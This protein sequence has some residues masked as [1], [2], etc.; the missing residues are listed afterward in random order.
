MRSFGVALLA[1]VLLGGSLGAS[2][3]YLIRGER[4]AAVEFIGEKN[5]KA[6]KELLMSNLKKEIKNH[7]LE[8]AVEFCSKNAIGLTDMIS[9]RA[10]EGVR[11]KRVSEQYRNPANKPDHAD[12]FAY[13]YFEK[14]LKK[15][16]H[17]PQNFV[18]RMRHKMNKDIEIF[19][20]FEPLYIQE[21]CLKCHGEKVDPK[22][23]AKIKELY[24]DDK[25]TGYKLGDLR[26]FVAVEVTLDALK[27]EDK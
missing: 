22:V 18:L 7:G 11:L 14:Y 26:G 1:L 13:T 9:E 17:Y 6:L 12:A 23:K 10:G 20:Y 27:K 3:E 19:R 4:G 15:E 8:G 16:G 2:E 21:A 25:A 5:S 24:P